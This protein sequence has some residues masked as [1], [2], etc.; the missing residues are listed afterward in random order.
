[1]I[2]FLV[3]VGMNA[4]VKPKA[5]NALAQKLLERMAELGVRSHAGF[6]GGRQYCLGVKVCNPAEAAT[7]GMEL[8]SGWG[9]I[10]FD[11]HPHG[12][13]Y[14]VFRDALVQA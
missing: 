13:Q 1:M 8:G 9:D 7:I 6:F 14:V 4:L 3:G 12:H 10:D 5:K 11:L 2:D